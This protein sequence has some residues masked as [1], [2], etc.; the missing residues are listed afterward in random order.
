MQ[1]IAEIRGRRRKVFALLTILLLVLN[2]AFVLLHRWRADLQL[3]DSL[4]S[5]G[6]T[7]Q[8][9]FHV[10][11]ETTYANM[12]QLATVI[13]DDPRVQQTFADG[14][15]AWQQE[16]GGAG[17]PRTAEVRTRLLALVSPMWH[18]QMQ[19]FGARQLQ[20]HFGP[21]AISFLRVQQ[22]DKF[23]EQLDA[24]RQM[25][26]DVNR[27]QIPRAGLELG[28]ISAG[29]RGVV[30]VW[31]KTKGN[32]ASFIGALEVGTSFEPVLQTL[33]KQTKRGAAI[34][35]ERDAINKTM[36]K[37]FVNGYQSKSDLN[38]R[39]YLE[40][41]SN[42]KIQ[43]I[44]KNRT[45]RNS[46]HGGSYTTII[47]DNGNTYAVT[48]FPLYSYSEQHHKDSESIGVAVIWED[49]TDRYIMHTNDRI[50]T[51]MLAFGSFCLFELMLIAGFRYS[52]Q[53]LQEMIDEQTA[54]I[55]N[56]AQRNDAILNAAGDAIIGLDQ[57][58]AITFANHSTE[59]LS[60]WKIDELLGKNIHGLFQHSS[61]DNRPLSVDECPVIRCCTGGV[62]A[63][64]SSDIFHRKE[65]RPFK[66]NYL[67]TPLAD[68]NGAVLVFRDITERYELEQRIIWLAHH[69]PLTELLNRSAFEE[70]LQ[71][72]EGIC[73]RE[74]RNIAIL[75]ID[76]DGFKQVNDR[77]G[78]DAG[79]KILCETALRLKVILREVD[80][81]ARFGGDEFVAALQVMPDQPAGARM[82]ADRL[83][84]ALCKPVDFNQ[85]IL[86]IGASI[87]IACYDPKHE[88]SID[89]TIR[90]ADQALYQA[91]REGKN[92][93][94]ESAPNGYL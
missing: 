72:L 65:G 78:H 43:R 94:I 38:C 4:T 85:H 69:D 22:P 68:G 29:L 25:V 13:A 18:R 74:Q 92:R 75:Y 40:A 89:H 56:L 71:T 17:G 5:E 35:F 27:D 1:P 16:G 60:G 20:F 80:I 36:L 15:K 61:Q 3:Q 44:L 59:L 48:R 91:K 58:G 37:E 39:Y 14:K 76:L 30:P 7:M 93:V 50:L 11:L 34:L 33:E 45:F 9:T 26:V 62:S 28:K 52:C 46:F 53:R 31:N 87:G 12:Q 84:H 2:V 83:L 79:D 82:V 64:A 47:P 21:G 32:S 77:F 51:I 23:G 86:Q 42:Q 49:I 6:E 55:A 19:L 73:R 8:A 90:R 54:E 70:K 88:S 24:I 67:V 81:V 57:T 63:E 10:I 66:V 41:S